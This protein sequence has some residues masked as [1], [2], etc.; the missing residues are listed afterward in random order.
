MEVWIFENE[1]MITVHKTQN[2]ALKRFYS[3]LKTRRMDDVARDAAIKQIK[4][5]EYWEDCQIY[6]TELCD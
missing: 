1:D 3:Y 2:G 6:S 5:Y 4:E